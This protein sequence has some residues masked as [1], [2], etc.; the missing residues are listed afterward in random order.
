MCDGCEQPITV[1][2]LEYEADH[3]SGQ[4]HRFHSKCFAAWHQARVER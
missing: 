3:S 2:D 4:S 1:S